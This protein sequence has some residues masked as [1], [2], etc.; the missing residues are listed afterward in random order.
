VSKSLS[1]AYVT[2]NTTYGRI[3]AKWEIITCNDEERTWVHELVVPSNSVA[4]LYVP[5]DG[6]WGRPWAY[7][8][9]RTNKEAAV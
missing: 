3:S 2:L 4:I 7:G 9:G 8:R 5:L 1:S 6:G